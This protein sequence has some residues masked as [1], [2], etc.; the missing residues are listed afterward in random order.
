MA[1]LMFFIGISVFAEDS[2]VSYFDG[3]WPQIEIDQNRDFQLGIHVHNP[4]HANYNGDDDSIEQYMKLVAESGATLVRT[5]SLFINQSQID[6]MDKYLA[7]AEAYGLDVM[8]VIS[9]N[10]HY[11]TAEEFY[12]HRIIHDCFAEQ[13]GRDRRHGADQRNRQGA[14]H[15][16]PHKRRHHAEEKTQHGIG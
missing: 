4:E 16:C 2:G 15:P 11:T 10:G 6:Y 1:I 8:F 14:E 12:D 9:Y 3:K 13:I 7:T 5:S